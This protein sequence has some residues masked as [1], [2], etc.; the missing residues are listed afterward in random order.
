MGGGAMRVAAAILVLVALQGQALSPNVSVQG[1]VTTRVKP[2]RPLRVTFDQKVCGAEVPDQ[3]VVVD[4]A[5]HLANAVITLVGVKARSA[6]R[7]VKVLNDRC[8]FVPRV[9]VAGSQATMKTSSNDP[10][11]HTTTVQ[12][13]DGRQL[14]NVAL[15]VPGLE[16]VKPLEGTGALRV[17]CSTH[18]WMR[19]WVYVTDD[20][21]VVTGPDGRFTLP[22]VPPG[23]YRLRVWHESLKAA[24][25]TVTVVAGRPATV[26][27]ELK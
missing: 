7:E 18:Q 2:P 12:L 10:I 9:Q 19:G 26:A 21:A 15:P 23:T 17:G 4:G 3:S 5:G 1:V 8:A 6:P 14:F 13:G 20:V 16:I 25:Q 22:A 11:L 27:V 24:D